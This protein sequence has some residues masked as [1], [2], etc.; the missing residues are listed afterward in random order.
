MNAAIKPSRIPSWS[1][2]QLAGFSIPLL[3]FHS[4]HGELRTV[5]ITLLLVI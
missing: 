3:V 1:I 2:T 4:T 5:S